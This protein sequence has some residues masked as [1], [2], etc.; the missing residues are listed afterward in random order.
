MPR[1]VLGVAGGIAAYKAAELLRLFTESGHDVQVVPTQAALKFVGEATWAALSGQPGLG[2]RLGRRRT[3]CRTCASAGGRPRGGG[4]GHRRPDGPGRPR[5]RPT[6]CSTNVLLTARCPV[7]MAPAMHTEMWEHAATQANVATLRA[8]GVVV[9]DPPR[10]G[11]PAPTPARAGCPSPTAIFAVVRARSWRAVGARRDLAGRRVVVSAGGTRE[12]LDPVRFLG[13]R[14]AGRRVTRS[15]AG[16]WREA[17]TSRWWRRTSRCPTPPGVD[18]VAVA[19]AAELRTRC[20][21]H[22]GRRRRRR[23]GGR[24]GRL[25]AG[26]GRRPRSRSDD[27]GGVPRLIALERTA[28]VLAELV[29]APR[30]RRSSAGRGR[31]RG[32]DRRR[33]GH[34]AR[35]RPRQAAPQGLRPARGQRRGPRARLRIDDNEVWMLGADGSASVPWPRAASSPSPTRSG[36]PSSAAARDLSRPGHRLD[37]PHLEPPSD[38]PARLPP[39]L[40]PSV[41]TRRL[42]TS[43]SVTEGHPD[44]IADQISDSILDAMLED[45]PQSRVAVETLITTGLVLVAGEVTTTGVR[46]HP[47]DRARADPRDRLRLVEEGLRRRVVRR[48]GLDRLAVARHRP[49]C[50]RRVRGARRGLAPTRSTARAPATRA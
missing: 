19:S 34:R 17:P 30:R 32:R 47:R 10:A 2:R 1:V 43:E 41:V 48:L 35:P 40:E 31:L 37:S 22:A 6:T 16:R 39:H 20:W 27:A 3:R 46:R 9:L 42:F 49:G 36:T 50:R 24:R 11:S 23:D 15:R 13:N 45:D 28:D 25:P 7:V 18:V 38:S 29:A 4:A 14:S 33:R 8:R 5:A 44:K 12:H 21:P 26:R